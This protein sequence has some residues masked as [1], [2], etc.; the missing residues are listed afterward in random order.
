[1]PQQELLNAGISA[2]EGA[3]IP[4]ML[5][6]SVVSSMQGEPRATHNVDVIVSLRA[7][8]A[9]RHGSMFD[10]IGA[11]DGGKVDFWMLGMEH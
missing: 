11:G 3:A 9:I 2:L 7:E 1:M 8:E 6:G 5:T 10:L 4:Y